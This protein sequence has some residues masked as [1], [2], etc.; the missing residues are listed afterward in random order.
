MAEI[1]RLERELS[2]QRT[3]F[4]VIIAGLVLLTLAMAMLMLAAQDN[5]AKARA[6]VK[7]L[8]CQMEALSGDDLRTCESEYEAL[9]AR[10]EDSW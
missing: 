6:E 5:A 9:I 3:M 4:G 10:I 7:Y 1:D 8:Q 2:R